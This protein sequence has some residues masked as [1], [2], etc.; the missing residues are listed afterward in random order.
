VFW[1]K[2]RTSAHVQ[3]AP[4]VMTGPLIVLALGSLISWVLV[5]PLTSSW[6]KTGLE[7]L[8]ID[9]LSLLRET[10]SSRAFLI[11]VCV[12]VLGFL[13]FYFRQSLSGLKEKIPAFFR[14]VAVGF[15]FDIFYGW[16]SQQIYAASGFLNSF[17]EEKVMEGINKTTGKGSVALSISSRKMQT[18]DLHWNL[19]YV[20]I[21]L[22]IIL[23]IILW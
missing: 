16:L 8:S 4:G 23:G 12:I 1:G 19:L 18:G 15:G 14:A 9:W 5:G 3:E 21:A 20:V 22:I 13:I 6:V 11:T 10:F 2:R 17:F 7:A